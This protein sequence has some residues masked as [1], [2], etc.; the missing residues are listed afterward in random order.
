MME[1]SEKEDQEK[2]DGMVGL[3]ADGENSQNPGSEMQKLRKKSKKAIGLVSGGAIGSVIPGIGSL[4]G[5]IIGYSLA[6]SRWAEGKVNQ[7]LDK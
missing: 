5:A 1:L 6:D 3:L 2:L 4:L 7:W